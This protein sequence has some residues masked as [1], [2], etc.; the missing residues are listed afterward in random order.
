MAYKGCQELA[1]RVASAGHPLRVTAATRERFPVL[2]GGGEVAGASLLALYRD[3]L[4]LALAL[5]EPRLMEAHLRSLV[6]LLARRGM[7]VE[8]MA[9]TLGDFI[10]A[11][12]T[13][14]PPADAHTV[15]PVLEQMLERL[16]PAGV[17][18]R[19]RLLQAL[20]T[21]DVET[22]RAVVQ[23][24]L[25]HGHLHVY[26]QLVQPALEEVG[27]LWRTHRIGVADEHLA[28]SVARMVVSSLYP[29]F[30]W[31][32]GGPRALVACVEGELHDFGVQL[33][34]DLLALEGW[35]TQSLGGD[36][37]TDELVRWAREV[38]P[39][40]IGLSVATAARLPVAQRAAAVLRTAVP[41]VPVLLGG[42][43]LRSEQGLEAR[44]LGVHALA[45]GPAE[46]LAQL[47]A[48]T[49]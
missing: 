25:R 41:G 9:G 29:R 14:L 30:P 36:T 18:P 17:T 37:P 43:V 4:S 22:A 5:D 32:H 39:R 11:L 40:F 42:Q 13:Q 21:G 44:A 2:D 35:D 34:A 27:E 26:E 46:A 24:G 16:V 19:Q 49:H 47:S 45:H 12:R 3:T 7:G 8:E 38:H 20:L 28:V 15:I 6:P 33:L 31:P 23:T 10:D 48:W 1:A